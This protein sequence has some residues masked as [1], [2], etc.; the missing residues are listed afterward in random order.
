[1][2][3]EV[4]RFKGYD[5]RANSN[6]VLQADRS[7][8][9]RRDEAK[10]EP[11]TL[12]GRIDPKQ[13]G[14]RALR[15][16]PEVPEDEA[17][18]KRKKL[19]GDGPDG[20]APVDDFVQPLKKRKK[21]TGITT[22]YG[23]S[24]II[25]AT[26]DFE[27]LSYRPRTKQ[28]RATYELLLGFVASRLGDQP[29]DVLRGAADEILATLKTE[30]LKDFDK[31]KR[32]E[33]MLGATVSS[34]DFAQLVGIGKRITDYNAEEE[35]SA[36]ADDDGM[37]NKT[38]AKL[39][40]GAIDEETGV[41]VV[42]EDDDEEEDEGAGLV[43]DESDEDDGEDGEDDGTGEFRGDDAAGQG[44]GADADE[45]DADPDAMDVDKTTKAPAKASSAA[46][47][48]SAS[49]TVDP[50]EV[51]NDPFWVQRQINLHIK[52]AVEAQRLSLQVLEVLEKSSDGRELENKLLEL[53]R[54]DKFELVKLFAR[55]QATIFWCS[56]LARAQNE[57]EKAAVEEQMSE[58]PKLAKILDRLKL[59]PLQEAERYG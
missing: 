12:S 41:A 3:E 33:D 18:K 28:T 25:S 51:F 40:A 7:R 24:N 6:L 47:S 38:K 55:N 14:E 44:N 15:A 29:Q 58:D 50:H 46:T 13:F 54:Y 16:R 39:A 56:K 17:K 42:F 57:K 52:E 1:M 35:E 53:L 19:Q 36:A 49:G 4:L 30:G 5:Y 59:N 27:G 10:G 37:D 48:S 45:E 11:E 32:S 20:A 8:L 34:E 43:R 31:K 9:P 22:S 23:A 21:G 26:D 2:A